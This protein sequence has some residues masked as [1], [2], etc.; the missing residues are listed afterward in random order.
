MARELNII[1]GELRSNFISNTNIKTIYNLTPGN[2]FEEEFSIV[3]FEAVL[4][5][6]IGF[7]IWTL[8]KIFDDHKT[9]MVSEEIQRRSWNLPTLVKN[10]KNFQFGDTLTFINGRYQYAAQ[11][12]AL[13]L[14]KLASA[15]DAGTILVLKVA[16]LD[17]NGFPEQLPTPV[18]TAFKTY[19]EAVIPPGVQYA[20]VS[21]PADTLKIYYRVY[22]DP[23]VLDSNG[24]SLINPTIKPVE[25]AIQDY[26][27]GLNF[28]GVF[29]VTELTDLIQ[30]ATG[31]LNPVFESA[32]AKYGLIAYAP[33][34]DYY[35]PNA[36]YLI[37][38]PAFPLDTTI[39]YILP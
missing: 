13:K 17:A 9:W 5:Y 34:Q 25:V 22:I 36:G 26:C 2:T 39:T 23:L 28:N 19:I 6:I 37:I 16:G 14:V 30:S 18:F 24:A 15:N 4:L 12:E 31:V 38:D 11:N 27:K 20:C 10:A 3:S 32:D 33:I 35:I 29:S 8:E 21:R 7:S 1:V